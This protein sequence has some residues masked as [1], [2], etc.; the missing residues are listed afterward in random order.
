MAT[1]L[2]RKSKSKAAGEQNGQPRKI[3]GVY[4]K[5]MLETKVT[6]AIT[7]IGQNIKPNLEAKVNAKIAGKCI[8]DG[9][10]IHFALT[11]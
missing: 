10:I 8:A 3:Y 11:Y 9:Y 5:S 1:V 7:E 6:L 2:I 4:M